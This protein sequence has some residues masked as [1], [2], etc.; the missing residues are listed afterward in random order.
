MRYR[1]VGLP[2]SEGGRRDRDLR[3]ARGPAQLSAA[4]R[5]GS[6]PSRF[7]RTARVNQVVREVV[8]DTLERLADGDERLSMLTVTSVDTSP[9]LRHATVFL[10]T[11]SDEA[12]ESLAEHRGQL[13][14][15]IARQV[16]LKRTPL[17]EFAADPAVAHGSKVEQILRDIQ[18]SG[19]QGDDSDER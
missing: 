16:R 11:L 9:D 14:R 4:R 13:Q 10:S 2:G 3:G 7:P 18:I 12:A 6:G 19:L 1:T 8:A 17:L 5:A 15:A